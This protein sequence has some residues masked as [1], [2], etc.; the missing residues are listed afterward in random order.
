MFYFF[1]AFTLTLSSLFGIDSKEITANTIEKVLSKHQQDSI[2]NWD[3]IMMGAANEL[4]SALPIQSY[5]KTIQEALTQLIESP[6]HSL[7]RIPKTR[8]NAWKELYTIDQNGK[9]LYVIKLYQLD[10]PLFPSEFW[11]Q[12]CASL[13]P[14]QNS[15]IAQVVN[16]GKIFAEETPYF[17]SIETF[18]EGTSFDDIR[19]KEA[20]KK[21]G[22]S[23]KEFHTV[24]TSSHTTLSPLFLN[25]MEH[26]ISEGI[27]LLDKNDREWVTPLA[28]KL[29][30]RIEKKQLPR[31]YVHGDPNLANFL[32][33]KEKIALIDFEAAGE[34]IDFSKKGLATPLFDLI[35]L[36]DYLDDLQAPDLKN[37]FLEGYGALPYDQDTIL[38]FRLIDTL[39][40]V[41]WFNGAKNNM[42]P[43]RVKDVQK[44]IRL[45]LDK[46]TS[47]GFSELPLR[48]SLLSS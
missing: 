47:L 4:A 18:L 42:S 1:I 12:W 30:E 10:S 16:A 45:K 44:T 48:P 26:L 35:P 5:G 31:S 15:S 6:S 11:G 34:Y 27:A 25:A 32:L 43:E 17:F 14:L 38:Y 46:L 9:S 21:L 20:F 22:K 28:K 40:A 13:L 2:E 37:A 36:W 3:E 7:N 19:E 24:S 29:K 8:E 39:N 23:L 41:E 33:Q